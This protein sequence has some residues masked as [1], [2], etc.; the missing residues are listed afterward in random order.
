M[1]FRYTVRQLI[2]TYRWA[3]ANPDGTIRLSGHWPNDTLT[4]A[5]WRRWFGVC[6]DRKIS[7]GDP[8]EE[9]RGRSRKC[10]PDWWRTMRQTADRLNNLRLII[11]WLPLELRG[12]FRHRLRD[13]C[14]L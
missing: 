1:A 4:G 13:E 6:L 8:R 12:R 3:R 5:E 10:D 9:A 2:E 11:D 14:C 7:A